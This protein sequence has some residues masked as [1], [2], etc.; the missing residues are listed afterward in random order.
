M[1]DFDSGN[2]VPMT[3]PLPVVLATFLLLVTVGGIVDLAFDRPSTWRSWHV[4]V[5]LLLVVASFGFAV[6]L[7]GYWRQSVT[8]LADAQASLA[9]A[10]QALAERQRERDAWRANAEQ[11]LAGF[12]AAIDRQFAQWQLTR[13][14]REVALLLLKG[15]GHKQ[16]AA[17]LGRSERT[18]R[19]QAVDVYRKA[20]IQGR[21]ELAAFFLQDVALPSESRGQT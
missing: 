1:T 14:E 10:S 3:G 18:V 13:A 15:L 12:G 21:A 5:E 7:F 8:A 6:L 2:S 11:A 4:A 17:Q 20:G 16:V 19:Q 9:S